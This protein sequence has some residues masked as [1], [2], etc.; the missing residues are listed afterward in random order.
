MLILCSRCGYGLRGSTRT[1]G[2]CGDVVC[3]KCFLRDLD[4]DHGIRCGQC[5]HDP[6]WAAKRY[7]VGS[8][9]KGVSSVF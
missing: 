9:P 8:V 6:E 2:L 5:N 4:S 7:K 3:E 1:C